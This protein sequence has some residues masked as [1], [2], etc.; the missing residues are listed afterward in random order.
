M[1]PKNRCPRAPQA[2]APAF[3]AQ[4][5]IFHKHK[6][7]GIDNE[8]WISLSCSQIGRLPK[9]PEVMRLFWRKYLFWATVCGFWG[10]GLLLAAHHHHYPPQLSTCYLCKSPSPVSNA[11]QTIKWATPFTTPSSPDRPSRTDV[12]AGIVALPCTLILAS[13][14]LAV[15]KNKAPPSDG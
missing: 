5:R 15:F 4:T 14:Y 12:P 2:P 1:C 8:I 6:N 9:G 13:P 10:A 11:P 7:I 3:F